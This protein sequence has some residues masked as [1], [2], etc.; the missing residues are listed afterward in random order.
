[1]SD[2]L[3]AAQ[4]NPSAR[5]VG[6][7]SVTGY[8]WSLSL[9][10]ADQALLALEV[11]GSP[12]SAGNGGPLRLVAPGHRGFQWVKW[13]AEVRVLDRADA[14]QWAAIFTSGLDRNA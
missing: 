4:A 10:E 11:G 7:R 9:D 1:M 13:V 5:Y 8:R 6:F 3:T 12:L 14:G 2:L